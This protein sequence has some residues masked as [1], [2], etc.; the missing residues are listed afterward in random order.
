MQPLQIQATFKP[1]WSH[2]QTECKNLCKHIVSQPFPLQKITHTIHS[3]L[4]FL[5]E[6]EKC[7]PIFQEDDWLKSYY[8][9][10]S[11]WLNKMIQTNHERDYFFDQ[12][13]W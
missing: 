8:L 11:C 1:H 5:R 6:D 7:Q 3:W 10:N 2:K 9:L 12:K 13:V 4:A